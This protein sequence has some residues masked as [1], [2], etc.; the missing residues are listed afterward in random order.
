[1]AAIPFKHLLLVAFILLCFISI[2]AEGRSLGVVSKSS[3]DGHQKSH[4]LHDPFKQKEEDHEGLL[5]DESNDLLAMDYTPAS[6]KPPIH[7]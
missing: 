3:D 4:D 6:K 7:N 5:P 1:M 2:T